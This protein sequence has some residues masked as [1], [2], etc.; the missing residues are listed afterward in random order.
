MFDIK[1]TKGMS[2]MFGAWSKSFNV[3]E[4]KHVSLGIASLCWAIWL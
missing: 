4:R 1:K 3:K 2:D